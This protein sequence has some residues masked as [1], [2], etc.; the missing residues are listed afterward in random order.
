[1]SLLACGIMPNHYQLVLHINEMDN[2]ASTMVLFVS[3]LM[4]DEM[5]A[6]QY[7]VNAPN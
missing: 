3:R 4:A 1:M 7:G 6:P 2:N 5:D